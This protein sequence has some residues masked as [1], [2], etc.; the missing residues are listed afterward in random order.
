MDTGNEYITKFEEIKKYIINKID[1][2]FKFEPTKNK[3]FKCICTSETIWNFGCQCNCLEL[4]HN[5]DI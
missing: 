5:K 1:N 2:F 3:P 4:V